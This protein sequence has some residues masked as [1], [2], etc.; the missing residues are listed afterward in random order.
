MRNALG[1]V[2]VLTACKNGRTE[3]LNGPGCEE[4]P[5]V[6]ALDEVTALGFS[7][8]DLL[9]LA[10]GQHDETFRWARDGSTTPMLLQVDFD[11]GEARYVDSV[12]VEDDA[13]GVE[14]DLAAICESR[15]EVDVM[16]A[17]STDDGAF[18]EVFSAPLTA[19]SA[20]RS[21]LSTELDPDAL[22]GTYDM[23]VDIQEP[24]YDERGLWLR[25][26]FDTM[27]ASGEV[28]GQISGEDECV[29]N[30]CA[31]W[32]MEV[33]VGTWGPVPE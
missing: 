33:P 27:G 25:A 28:A 22:T 4:T 31:A 29:G 32:A 15:V 11:A 17:F 1:I 16:I 23:D 13:N 19:T 12:P 5:T 21:E 20:A 2:L 30:A 6:V 18:D 9:D 3:D 24:D 14:P 26:G 10:Q 7:A 8:Q